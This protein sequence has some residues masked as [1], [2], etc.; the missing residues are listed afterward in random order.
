MRV[1]DSVHEIVIP[2]IQLCE[3]L[4]LVI[5]GDAFPENTLNFEH[6]VSLIEVIDEQLKRQR[7]SC[8]SHFLHYNTTT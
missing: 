6:I 8:L 3:N 7:R 5:N 4:V 1:G 2:V